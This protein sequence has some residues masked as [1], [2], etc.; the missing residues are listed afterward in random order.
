MGADLTRLIHNLRGLRVM[1][2]SDIAGIYGVETRT[3]NQAV[4]RHPERFPPDFTFELTR[5]EI[6]NMSQTVIC[7]SLKHSK[8][9][10]AFTETGVAMLS[11]VLRTRKAIAANI[12]I[13]RAFVAARALASQNRRILRKLSELESRVSRHD[14]EIGSL[15]DAIRGSLTEE[16]KPRRRIGFGS[17]E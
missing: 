8:R 13:M 3:L 9:V 4:K 10:A 2:D 14:T 11:S 1:L 16:E 7:S 5:S 12:A 6:R 17:D 15:I